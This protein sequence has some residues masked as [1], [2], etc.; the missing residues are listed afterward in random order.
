MST[1]SSV[2]IAV[3]AVISGIGIVFT[4]DGFNFTDRLLG[5]VGWIGGAGVGAGIGWGILPQLLSVSDR[6]ATAGTLLL[7]GAVAGRLLVPIISWLAVV[8]LGF[9]S[10]ST[11]ALVFFAGN[12]ILQTIMSV[13]FETATPAAVEMAIS[14]LTT[15]PA[16]QNQQIVGLILI[17][18]VVGAALTAQF[19][20]AIITLAATAFGAGLLGIAIPLWQRALTSGIAFSADTTQLSMLWFGVTLV[21][22]ICVQLYRYREEFQLIDQLPIEGGE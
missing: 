4:Y 10:V 5:W 20:E 16:F 8:V 11:A 7:A 13:Q 19:Y 14:E 22:G 12:Q 18:G 2:S 1:P 17:L 6:L 9:L 15:L 3:L 21:S